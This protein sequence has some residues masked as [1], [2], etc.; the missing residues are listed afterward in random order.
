[1]LRNKNRIIFHAEG[2]SKVGMGHV[3]RC[4]ALSQELIKRV[5]CD[6]SYLMLNS[7]SG[8]K[9]VI[10]CG[11]R[12]TTRMP[13]ETVDIIITSLPEVRDDYLE[14]LKKKTKLLV[15]IDDSK[16]DFFSAD[17][18]VRGSI[19]PELR[20]YDPACSGRFLLGKNYMILNKEF[21]KFSGRDKKINPVI[22]SVL[23]TLG[24]SD[25]NNFTP[26]VMDALDRL[27]LDIEKTVVLGPAFKNTER[28]KKYRGYKLKYNIS[29]MAD[30]MFESDLII[31]GGGMTLYELACVGTPAI[32]LCQ[33]EYQL[34]EANY[35]AKEDV[36]I[37][38]GSEKDITKKMIAHNVMLLFND[39]KKRKQMSIAG[40]RLIDGKGVERVTKE[41]LE[42][43]NK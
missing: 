28:L 24:G 42:R 13:N 34:L 17:I 8:E 23:I 33:T 12:T 6:I 21:Q 1:M 32:V 4:I 37:N 35:F 26:N 3:K 40:K 16:R 15:C 27:N 30:L 5:D 22:K 39:N 2:N 11:Y 9:E 38:L 18:V 10:E 31:A 7:D 25:V 43:I 41:I 20:R 29:N 19:V 14:Q 36:I